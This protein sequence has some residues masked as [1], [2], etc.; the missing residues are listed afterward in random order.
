MP[1]YMYARRQSGFGISSLTSEIHGNN[2]DTGTDTGIGIGIGVA[3]CT[4]HTLRRDRVCPYCLV[5]LVA[6]CRM[7]NARSSISLLAV[8][9][10]WRFPQVG[11]TQTRD[12]SVLGD[13]RPSFA[14]F[15]K[16]QVCLG[17]VKGSARLALGGCECAIAIITNQLS[18]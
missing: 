12:E 16:L 18:V 11:L 3:H 10:E 4:L 15:V 17:F 7:Q 1:Q 14:L 5:C 2:T 9:P 8:L 13:Q 6:L